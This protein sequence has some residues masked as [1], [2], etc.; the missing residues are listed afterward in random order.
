MYIHRAQ[1]L[2]ISEPDGTPE[3]TREGDL[4]DLR[5]ISPREGRS[6]WEGKNGPERALGEAP[7]E[8]GPVG[9][10]HLSSGEGQS[11]GT[12]LLCPC[13]Q[14]QFLSHGASISDPH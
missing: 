5:A 7:V 12:L 3:S 13:L 2:R 10:F 4:E 14:I 9:V 11:A 6:D 8:G 1:A